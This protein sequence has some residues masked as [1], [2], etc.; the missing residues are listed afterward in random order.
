M[1]NQN[2][3]IDALSAKLSQTVNSD[4][5]KAMNLDPQTQEWVNNVSG[6]TDKLNNS[7]MLT[8]D[9]ECQRDKQERKLYN[10]YV[11]LLDAA[12]K[13]PRE[14]EDAERN[15]YVFSK[16]NKFY[17]DMKEKKY[18]K[19]IDEQVSKYSKESKDSFKKI[20]TLLSYLT[21]QVGLKDNYETISDNY[22]SNISKIEEEISDATSK[23]NI[24]NR[25]IYYD[26]QKIDNYSLLNKVLFYI[27]Y[28]IVIVLAVIL[29]VINRLYKNKTVLSIIGFLAVFPYAMNFLYSQGVKVVNGVKR[30]YNY[31]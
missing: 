30:F 31:I 23:L 29:I 16:G 3:D 12:E 6:L 2:I 9:L 24:E 5:F 20:N 22:T 4:Q 11:R 15:F 25:N 21:N 26:N 28:F 18:K 1:S 17:Q 7:D 19:H 10:E 14:L 8:C 13:V 27:Y